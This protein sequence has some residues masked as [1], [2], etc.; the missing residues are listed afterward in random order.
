MPLKQHTITPELPKLPETHDLKEFLSCIFPLPVVFHDQSHTWT[1]PL[2]A[3]SNNSICQFVH[4]FRHF[5]SIGFENNKKYYLHLY[6]TNS[7]NK[8]ADILYINFSFLSLKRFIIALF[9][10]MFHFSTSKIS[11]VFYTFTLTT[12][13]PYPPEG[14]CKINGISS[15]SAII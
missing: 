12:C 9:T 6:W 15:K 5:S 1:L 3:G 14:V 10:S 13:M 11:L 4:H 7:E 2:H 8:K